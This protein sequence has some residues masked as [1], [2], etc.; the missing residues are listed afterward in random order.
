[1]TSSQEQRLQELEALCAR[2][3]WQ[4]EKL[5]TVMESNTTAIQAFVELSKHV[6]FTLALLGYMEKAAG[7]LTKMAAA[8]LLI[9]AIWKY[10]IKEALAHLGSK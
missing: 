2:N 10:A 7:W 5:T 4:I 1:M 6:K 8:A 3:A 9:W